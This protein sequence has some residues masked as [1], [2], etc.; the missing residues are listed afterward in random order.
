MKGEKGSLILVTLFGLTII[1]LVSVTAHRL[2]SSLI[3]T[4][5][6]CCYA[7]YGLL[8]NV[9]PIWLPTLART[10]LIAILL[11]GGG[12]LLRHLWQ[13]HRFVS[14]LRVATKSALPPRLIPLCT[15]LDLFDQVM[16]LDT[17]A[18]LAF[19]YGI[20]QPRICLS[21]GLVQALTDNELT[22][23]LLHEDYHRRHYDPLRT[24]LANA[25]A[26][27]LFFMPVVAEWRERFLTSAELAADGHAV[28]LAGRLPLAGA[29]HKLLTH[30]QAVH[31]PAPGVSSF[32]TT[33]VRIAY[34][35][36]NTT[37]TTRF[38]PRSLVSSSIILMLGCMILQLSLF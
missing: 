14:S 15:R 18:R 34:L 11:Y 17:P 32:S 10:V 4:W 5:T 24:L 23:V 7:L 19:C 9:G 21:T 29:L 2:M 1:C 20:L 28:C 22:A 12:A 25:L 13:T 3:P 16:M 36:N 27:I 38:S 26:T 33:E 8:L 6:V 31:L 37:P 35:L 30:P